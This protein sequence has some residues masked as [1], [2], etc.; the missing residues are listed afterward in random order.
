MTAFNDLVSSGAGGVLLL[1]P[2]QD[3]VQKLSEQVRESINALQDHL[4][5]TEFEIPVYFAEET[6]E[7]NELLDSLGG[8][9][10]KKPSA[11]ESKFKT[12]SSN[13]LCL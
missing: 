12:K 7:L 8:E 10:E 13:T 3:Q 11:Y 9:A 6:P 1:I 5:T 4:Y 2:N